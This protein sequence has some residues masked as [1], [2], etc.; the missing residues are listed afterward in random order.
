[1]EDR[2]ICHLTWSS[3]LTETSYVWGHWISF[4][5]RER[6]V[7]QK[8]I[9][10][11]P[12][13]IHNYDC[14]TWNIVFLV[15]SFHVEH[16]WVG[17][18]VVWD[19]FGVCCL[20]LLVVVRVGVSRETI[21]L[22]DGILLITPPCFTWNMAGCCRCW[23]AGCGVSRETHVWWV[24]KARGFTWN[25]GVLRLVRCVYGKLGCVFLVAEWASVAGLF[26]P[27]QRRMCVMARTEG[28]VLDFTV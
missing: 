28:M 19:D 13:V 1:M 18:W 4:L 14:F 26:S 11:F 3:L 15:L 2:K 16:G 27:F 7:F 12:F 6:G 21:P 17:V 24:S 5:A 22:M 25:V 9:F 23:K 10:S 8:A 20:P